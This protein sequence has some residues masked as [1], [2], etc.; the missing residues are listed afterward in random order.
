MCVLSWGLC[1]KLSVYGCLLVAAMLEDMGCCCTGLV[2]CPPLSLPLHYHFLPLLT[3][4]K[5]MMVMTGYP[6]FLLE[7][8]LI[9]QEYGVSHCLPFPAAA[10]G[11]PYRA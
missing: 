3:Q 8:E 11:H 9:D 4:L 1:P 2:V 7:P 5:H 10:F 6:D